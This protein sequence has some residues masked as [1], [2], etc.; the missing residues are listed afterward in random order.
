M[1]CIYER[2]RKDIKIMQNFIKFLLR[3]EN[4]YKIE[5]QRGEKKEDA[6]STT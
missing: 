4:I 1:S 2:D 6:L 5:R 3:K